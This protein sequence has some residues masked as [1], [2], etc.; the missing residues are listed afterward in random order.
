MEKEQLLLEM[1]KITFALELIESVSE[2]IKNEKVYS[3]KYE[4][5]LPIKR[6]IVHLLTLSASAK[7]EVKIFNDFIKRL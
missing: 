5:N 7:K 1:Q 2:K 6:N 4:Y 3:E